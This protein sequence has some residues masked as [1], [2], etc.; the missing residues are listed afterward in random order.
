MKERQ[1]VCVQSA[2]AVYMLILRGLLLVW[3]FSPPK[4]QRTE[5]I[6]K[7]NYEDA[8]WRLKPCGNGELLIQARF[9]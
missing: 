4:S 8:S 9:S 7:V 6:Q 3:N 1:G 2:D 5:V